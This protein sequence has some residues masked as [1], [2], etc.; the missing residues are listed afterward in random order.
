MI[1]FSPPYI[2]DDV[3]REVMDSLNSGWITTGPKVKALEQEVSKLTGVE[4]VLCVNSATSALMLMLHWFGIGKGDEVIVPAY[5]YCATALAVMHVGAKPVMADVGKDFCIDPQH[6]KKLINENT[7]AIIPVDIAGF[8]CDYDNVMEIIS[9]PSIAKLFKSKSVEQEKLGRIFIL[10]DAAHS[11]GAV[12]K[13]KPSGA[14]C[15]ATVFSFHAVKNV[16]TAEG[17]AICLNLPDAFDNNDLYKWLRLLSLNGQTKDA[18]TKSQGGNW[19][20]DIIYPGF[21]MNLSDIC[22][23]VGLAQIRKY[24]TFLLEKRKEIFRKYDEGFSSED[25][26]ELPPEIVDGRE[27]SCHIYLLRINGISEYQRDKIIEAINELGVSVN[28]HF[29]PMPMLTV[30]RERGYDINDYP[31]SLDNYSR[32]ITLPVYPQLSD[33]DTQTIIT[34][35]KEAYRK[36]VS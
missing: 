36:V 35:V 28:V 18:F 2:D 33:E 32:V 31:V 10:S 30:F 14:L 3:I 12:Y 17:G 6:V 29:V 25:W 11:I 21:K 19:R 26:A 16:T 27:S 15:D 22:A 13:G 9:E 20:Y 23:A 24:E 7:K 8:P 1:P 5:T 4:N 34:S